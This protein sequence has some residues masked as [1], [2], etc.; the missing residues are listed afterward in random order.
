M[1]EPPGRPADQPD[2]REDRGWGSPVPAEYGSLRS[3]GRDAS[4]NRREGPR[5]ADQSARPGGAWSPPADGGRR[6]AWDW[7]PARTVEASRTAEPATVPLLPAADAAGPG[8]PPRPAGIDPNAIGPPL[9]PP[10]VGGRRRRAGPRPVRARS[11]ATIRHVDVLTVARV[12]AVFWLLVIVAVVVASIMLWAFADAFG[13]LPS[14]EKSV[15][16][17]F[18]LKSFKF[19][20]ATVALYTAGAGIVLAVAGI[21]ASI[22]GAVIY[23][24]I[25]DVVGGVRVELETFTRD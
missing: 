3:G 21:L 13:A 10:A 4:A 1:S 17:L 23:N 6:S 15:R 8:A 14:I 18:S 2:R 22:L 20:P 16:T 24:L 9:G 11:R 25:A 19:H 12:S 5:P 7:A